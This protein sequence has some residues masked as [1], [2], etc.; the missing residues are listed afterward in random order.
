MREERYVVAKDNTSMKEYNI[1]YS[2]PKSN[3][4]AGYNRSLLM[5]EDD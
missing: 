3:E 1:A 5:S 4:S 2:G